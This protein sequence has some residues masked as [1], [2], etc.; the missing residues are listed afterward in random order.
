[1]LSDLID[2]RELFEAVLKAMADMVLVF[3]DEGRLIYY[4]IPENSELSLPPEQLLGLR[5][6]EAMGEGLGQQFDDAIEATR[7]GAVGTIEYCLE[8]QNGLKW[9]S[10]QISPIEEGD[11]FMGSVAV[12]H[13]IDDYKRALKDLKLAGILFESTIEGI[14]VCTATG[15]IR[16]VNPAFTA[17]TGY[18]A[19]EVIGHNPRVLKSDRHDQAFYQEMWDSLIKNGSW[20]GEIW[21]RR[22]NGETYPEFLAIN[23]VRDRTGKL[24]YYVGVFTDLSE[25]KLRDDLIRHQTYHDPLTNLPNRDLFED[26]LKVAARQHGRKEEVFAVVMLDIDNFKQVNNSLGHAVGDQLLRLVGERLVGCMRESDTVARMGADRFVMLLPAPG[27]RNESDVLA[28]VKRV[29]SGF[30]SPFACEGHE[31]HVSVSM[32]LALFPSDGRDGLTLLKHADQA[33]VHARSQGKKSSYSFYSDEMNASVTR[34]FALENELHSALAQNQFELFY[35]PVVEARSGMIRGAEALIR[36]RHPQR[37][38]VPPNEFIPLAEENGLITSITEWVVAKVLEDLKLI[39]EDISISLNISARDLAGDRLEKALDKNAWHGATDRLVFELTEN[40]LV[41]RRESV[42]ETMGRLRRRGVRFSI[43]DF[44]T[45]YSSLSYLKRFPLD[46]L[47]IDRSF[48]IDLPLDDESCGIVHAIIGLGKA[49]DLELI[50]EGVE[51]HH[52]LDFLAAEGCQ[53]IQGYY[54]S[55]PVPLEDFLKLPQVIERPEPGQAG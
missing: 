31:I 12:V 25:I 46:Y 55:K 4:N 9:F 37:G 39:P 11:R 50:A 38:L 35:Q 49:L 2:S 52:Q 26:R 29:Q 23:E 19:E 10:A 28:A 21:N 36:W 6:R 54:F 16:A 5:Y 40:I 41:D 8:T 24:N 13:D 20:Q 7:M 18:A 47:K 27:V 14:C 53:Y 3:D 44:G 43:D 34:R 32:G 1:M 30:A 51:T 22:K 48:V 17:I 15:A 45:G 33:I 42:L